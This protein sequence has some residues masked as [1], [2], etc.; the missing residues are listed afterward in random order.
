[1]GTLNAI[2][3]RLNKQPTNYDGAPLRSTNFASVAVAQTESPYLEATRNGKRMHGGTQILANGIAPVAA[4][5]T[6]TATLGLYNNDVNSNGLSLIIDWV[7][8]YLASGTPAAGATLFVAVAKPT[9]APTVNATGYSSGPLSG[10]AN[11]S[12]SLWATALTLPAGVVWSALTSTLQP[13]AANIGQGDS[14]L[15]LGG[16][17]VIPPGYALGMALLSGAGT[18]PIYGISAQWAE[19]ELDLA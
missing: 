8:F 18:T 2:I 10:T 7:N 16:R 12:K 13:A 19:L 1:M 14:P 4:I 15:D 6:T 5:P 3:S 9:T 17:I 11:G